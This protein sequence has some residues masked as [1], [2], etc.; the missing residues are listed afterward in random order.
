MF[1]L[2]GGKSYGLFKRYW[3]KVPPLINEG[4]KA[5]AMVKYVEIDNLNMNFRKLW[6]LQD[7]Y[8]IVNRIID[9]KPHEKVHT[10]VELIL[11][12]E[13]G[14]ANV[15]NQPEGT[16]GWA[17]PSDASTTGETID[18]NIDDEIYTSTGDTV[19]TLT[20]GPQITTSVN[21]RPGTKLPSTKN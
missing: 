11:K 9:Y 14:M 4:V 21:T 12:N 18:F 1:V 20:K 7:V 15:Q 16:D 3:Y 19:T 13:L 6:Y 2:D 17:N 5:S 10:K 8:W